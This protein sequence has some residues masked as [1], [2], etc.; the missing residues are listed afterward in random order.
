MARPSINAKLKYELTPGS[1]TFV[2]IAAVGSISGPN[3]EAQV[4]DITAH[5]TV[6]AFRRKIPTLLNA[7]RLQFTLF[8]DP[9]TPTHNAT[10]LRYMYQNRLTRA[11]RLYT[12]E[13]DYYEDFDGFVS[14][15]GAAYTVDGVLTQ[16]VSIEIDGSAVLTEV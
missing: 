15:L 13:E 8:Y 6:G 3:L 1:G 12:A 16:N 7:G 14:A 11:F 9:A 2:E 5:D 10:G 4:V